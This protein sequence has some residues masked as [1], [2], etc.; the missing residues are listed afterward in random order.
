MNKERKPADFQLNCPTCTND[1]FTDLVWDY[2]KND[3]TLYTTCWE[4]FSKENFAECVNHGHTKDEFLAANSTLLS[5][6]IALMIRTM[7]DYPLVC[8]LRNIMLS[9]I[10]FK[11]L[12]EKFFDEEIME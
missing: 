8:D 4:I 9:A 6:I 1:K 7:P 3:A 12:S 10:N 2:I 11:A 5:S